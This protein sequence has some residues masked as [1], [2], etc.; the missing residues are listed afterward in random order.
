[1]RSVPHRAVIVLGADDADLPRSQQVDGDDVLAVRSRVGERDQ[2]GEDRQLL[3]DAVLAAQ[4]SLVFLYSGADERTGSALPPAVPLG[5]IL[6]DLQGRV[7]T[8]Q[9][10][11][12]GDLARHTH[13]PQAF[14]PQNF[15]R[16]AVPGSFDRAS[17]AG[18]GSWL[19]PRVGEPPFLDPGSLLRPPEAT[20]AGE[21]IEL[22]ELVRFYEHP[23]R[24]IAR[25]VLGLSLA[26]F[27][28]EL[29]TELPLE[30][31]GLHRWAVGDRILTAALNGADADQARAGERRRGT[32]PPGR[33]GEEVADEACTAVAR[34]M[35]AAHPYLAEPVGV[36]DAS[37]HLDGAWLRGA[38]AMRGNTLT[39]ITY[40]GLKARTR[41]AS[42][43]RLLAATAA[44]AAPAPRAVVIAGRRAQTFR[45]RAPE[46]GPAHRLL[47]ELVR[48][49][50]I[51]RCEVLPL[52]VESA[53]R[54]AQAW[55]SNDQRHPGYYV[56]Q[57]AR[58]WSHDRF[59]E[60]QDEYHRLLLPISAEE[61]FERESLLEPQ[62]PPGPDRLSWFARLAL[63]TFGSL[64]EFEAR[65]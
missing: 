28:T 14:D 25:A 24:Y 43:I 4:E 58:V 18:A 27:S 1:M 33:L 8:S 23:V 64:L 16:G 60:N 40:S 9:G 35:S 57:V 20:P 38:V 59:P 13:P 63:T 53:L 31:D 36:V 2:A 51:G 52:P 12:G 32:L 34:I 41:I 39:T 29:E 5:E 46:P 21:T 10:V 48:G 17:A 65:P 44:G 47:S 55:R 6:D 19:S 7:M 62:W 61:L 37:V 11:G 22:D 26:D 3:L 42:W 15:R 45:L 30:L 54:F 50:R 56:N 49:Y